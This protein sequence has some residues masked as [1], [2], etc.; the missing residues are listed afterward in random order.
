MNNQR[1]TKGDLLGTKAESNLKIKL[2]EN[3]YN[4]L[5]EDKVVIEY[6]DRDKDVVLTVTKT[7]KDIKIH[8][9][10]TVLNCDP[11]MVVYLISFDVF[12]EIFEKDIAKQ[13]EASF[14]EVKIIKEEKKWLLQR[15]E[16]IQKLKKEDKNT[17]EQKK[18]RKALCN[19]QKVDLIICL[20]YVF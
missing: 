17:K 2:S 4:I 19:I 11:I 12:N 16:E 10:K 15:K 14:N 7:R 8:K 13:K 20:F 1:V 3:A 6:N 18:K 5:H 9:E